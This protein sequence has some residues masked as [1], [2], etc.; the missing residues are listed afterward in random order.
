M[1]P[2]YI[3]DG[4]Y[5]SYNERTGHLV[6]TTGNHEAAKA[7]AVIYLEPVVIHALLVYIARLESEGDE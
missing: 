6:L 1:K 7:D 4:V 3:G 2:E 5:A